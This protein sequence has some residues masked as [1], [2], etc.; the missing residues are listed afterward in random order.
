M[1]TGGTTALENF[2][3]LESTGL[4]RPSPDAQ[5]REVVVALGVAT[6]VI[7][8]GSGRPITHWALP[9]LVRLNPGNTP[10][11][12]AP[13]AEAS[14]VL[15]LDDAQMVAALDRVQRALTAK[16]PRPGL[17]RRR[18]TWA[19]MALLAALT[20]GWLPGALKRQTLALVPAVTRQEI[21]GMILG[22]MQRDTGPACRAQQGVRALDHLV[23]RL[24]GQSSDLSVVIL[25]GDMA[26][27]VLL[28]GGLI[29][30]PRSSVAAT[31]DPMVLAGDIVAALAAT[32][33]EDPLQRVLDA[34]GL[35][36]TLT[37]LA[38]GTL[39]AAHLE[40]LARDLLLRGGPMPPAETLLPAFRIASLPVTPWAL[41]QGTASPRRR[42]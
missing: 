31:D 14:E 41:A 35:R 38:T 34:A 12:F 20:A 39:P 42:G 30:L 27:P 40:P 33:A 15:E 4:W 3:R 29:V 22:L 10:A 32:A 7:S 8:E 2:A 19:A 25:P 26:G 13:D 37:L 24:Y 1:Q 6:L 17:L 9:A 21:G 18:G 11:L 16:R 23:E 36:A 28:P 5:R